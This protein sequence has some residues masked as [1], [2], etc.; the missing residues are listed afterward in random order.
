M[1]KRY[2][3]LAVATVFLAFQLL[4]GSASAVDINEAVRT[5]PADGSGGT[6]TASLDDLANGE[7]KFNFACSICHTGGDT[8][9]NPTINLSTGALEGATPSRNNVAALVDYMN[10]PTTY[11]GFEEIA[12][13]H[14]S[15]QSTDIFPAMR[16]FTEDDLVNVAE[17]I[18]VRP[19]VVGDQ[20]GGGKSTR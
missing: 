2:M 16:N 7:R 10:N 13:L 15:T 12:E 6:V 9:T 3:L 17:Y 11:D 4:T 19:N 1:L 14:P 8:K 5:V 20:W 18:L